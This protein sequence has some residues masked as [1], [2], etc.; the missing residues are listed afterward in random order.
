MIKV[1]RNA[2]DFKEML[3]EITK[4]KLNNENED[5]VTQKAKVDLDNPPLRPANYKTLIK[6]ECIKE[7]VEV[8]NKMIN[9]HD[10]LVTKDILKDRS[11]E[12][13]SILQFLVFNNGLTNAITEVNTLLHIHHQDFEDSMRK[14]AR[15]E[16]LSIEEYA[17]KYMLEDIMG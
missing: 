17:I 14:I 3:E 8:R 5:S 6:E 13:I 7:L 4:E 16:G 1:I 9:I 12:A 15:E 10:K 11:K 2:E